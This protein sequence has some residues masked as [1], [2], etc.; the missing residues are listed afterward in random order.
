MKQAE[1][2][3]DQARLDLSL[4]QRALEGAVAAAHAEAE[5]AFTQV[6]ILRQ[7]VDTATESLRLTLLRYQAG[8]ATALEVSDAQSTV[9]TARDS[10]DDGL[11]RY[12][13]AIATLRTLMGQL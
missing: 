3:Q 10:Y 9:K 12:R 6:G 11:A 8:E 7:S 5:G 13:I 1:L 2:K 4:T